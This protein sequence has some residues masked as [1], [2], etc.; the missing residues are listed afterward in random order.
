MYTY[1]YNTHTVY[2]VHVHA[3]YTIVCSIWT[4]VHL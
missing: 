4:I 2:D 3:L 1:I